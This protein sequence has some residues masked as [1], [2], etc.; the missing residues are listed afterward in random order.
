MNII[1]V[2][3]DELPKKCVDCFYHKGDFYSYEFDHWCAV[4]IGKLRRII[5][6]NTRPSWCPLE[7]EE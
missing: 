1:K 5:N 4:H 2:I 7:S 3:V 6:A